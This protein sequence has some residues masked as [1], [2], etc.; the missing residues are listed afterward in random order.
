[1]QG[2][3]GAARA[4]KVDGKH[5]RIC[6]TGYAIEAHHIVPRSKF[7]KR[8]PHVHHADNLMPLCHDCHQRHHTTPRRVPRSRL[9]LA[10]VVFLERHAGIVWSGKWYPV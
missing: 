3:I 5:C 1:V 10:E 7:G 8:N 9:T 2:E 6:L 4:E